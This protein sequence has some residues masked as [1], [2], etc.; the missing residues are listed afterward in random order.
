[1]KL[2]ITCALGA[3]LLASTAQA[4]PDARGGQAPGGDYWR[5]CRDVS[6]YGYGE[7]A[8]MTAKCQDERG[9]WRNTSLR[10]GRCREVQ[11]RNGDLVCADG[12]PGDGDGR[13]PW[14]GG[15]RP[16]WGG[17]DGGGR[18]GYGRGSITLFSAPN[19]AGRPFE[20]QGEITNLPKQYNDRAL[21]LRVQ[22]RGAWQV[23]SDSDFR[24]RCQVFDRDVPDLR[25]YGLG[26]AVSS[27]RP[28]R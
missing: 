23:C 12:R 10:F 17:G 3:V 16:P 24:G 14:A 1:M 27:M 21:S 13:P 6:T 9:R 19:F 25:Q 28:V 26:E 18:P 20:T 2:L 8:T 11:N 4:Q 7:D 15:G 5:T 22:G